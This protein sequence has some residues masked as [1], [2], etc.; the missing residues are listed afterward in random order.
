MGSSTTNPF[1]I[2]LAL[3]G[4]LA[5]VIAVRD[6]SRHSASQT[7]IRPVLDTSSFTEDGAQPVPVPTPIHLTKA[8]PETTQE[9]AY[10]NYLYPQWPEGFNVSVQAAFILGALLCAL[11]H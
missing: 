10:E 1:A 5:I 9:C 3:L 2:A 8:S 7:A 6:T 4:A 11:A